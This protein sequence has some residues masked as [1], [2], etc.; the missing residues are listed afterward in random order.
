VRITSVGL[1]VDSYF[2]APGSAVHTARPTVP[3]RYCTHALLSN[4][5]STLR[6]VTLSSGACRHGSQSVRCMKIGVSINDF[7]L[8]GEK[9]GHV[10][11]TW[12]TPSFALARSGV[13]QSASKEWP[14]SSQITVRRR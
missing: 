8:T 7:C 10:A 1:A 4:A 2:D 3:G 13:L 6:H 9:N 5:S 11:S 12:G 14:R